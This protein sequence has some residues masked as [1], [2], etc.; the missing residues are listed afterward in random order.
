[1]MKSKRISVILSLL[2]LVQVIF[3]GVGGALVNELFQ[4]ILNVRVIVILAMS[5]GLITAI[6]TLTYLYL[7]KNTPQSRK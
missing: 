4:E 3:I 7:F 1:M 5:W 6:G 2:T